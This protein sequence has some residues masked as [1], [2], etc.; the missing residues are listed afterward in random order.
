MN[1]AISSV[2]A[3]VLII[4]FFYVI[5]SKKYPFRSFRSS[6]LLHPSGVI[7]FATLGACSLC[8]LSVSSPDTS[9][10]LI[11]IQYIMLSLCLK[12]SNNPLFVNLL[13]KG[14]I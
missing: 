8:Q 7:A 10:L 4:I 2:T 5:F 12:I 14:D 11:T 13:Y 3:V 1:I 6:S 9:P